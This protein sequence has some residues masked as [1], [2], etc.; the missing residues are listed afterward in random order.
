MELHV[1]DVVRLQSG[2]PDMTVIEY[3]LKIVLGE[4]NPNY[5]RCQWFDENGSTSQGTF[6][7]ETLEKVK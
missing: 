3:P 1:G 6:L 2:G 7:V 4:D 5:T